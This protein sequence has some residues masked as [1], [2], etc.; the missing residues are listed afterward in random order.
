MVCV[1]NADQENI[2]RSAIE[3]IAMAVVIT[4][5]M[6]S[7]ILMIE[8]AKFPQCCGQEMKIRTDLGKFIEIYCNACGDTIYIKKQ[9]VPKPQMLDD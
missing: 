3:L 9:E 2:P 5:S 4:N 1:R 8:K 7:G 6:K